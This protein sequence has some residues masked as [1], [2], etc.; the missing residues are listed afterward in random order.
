MTH[1]FSYYDSLIK[2]KYEV[3]KSRV[4]ESHKGE[5]DNCKSDNAKVKVINRLNNIVDNTFSY[6]LKRYQ[7]AIW[8]FKRDIFIEFDVLHNPKAEL[9]YQKCYSMGNIEGYEKVYEWFKYLVELIK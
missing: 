9:L 4:Y 5:L 7:T 6:Q 1:E 8:E 2:P 3:I